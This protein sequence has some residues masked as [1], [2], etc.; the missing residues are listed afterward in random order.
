MATGEPIDPNKTGLGFF[1]SGGAGGSGGSFFTDATAVT[2]NWTA[3]VGLGP[4]EKL[5]TA[6]LKLASDAVSE[7]CSFC[8]STKTGQFIFND[9]GKPEVRLCSGCL[10]KAVA[11][12]IAQAQGGITSGTGDD[13][14]PCA[15]CHRHFQKD[16]LHLVGKKDP[17]A[18]CDP[19]FDGFVDDVVRSQP[20]RNIVL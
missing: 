7:P 1:G 20:R 11:W 8:G 16:H 13:K 2:S 18:I 10:T 5:E 19:C 14:A 15:K 4:Q 6:T 3:T 12:V 9:E 17:I